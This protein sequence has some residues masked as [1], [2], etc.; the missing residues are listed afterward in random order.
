MSTT[1]QMT[2]RVQ[3]VS[4]INTATI[5]N[6]V[7]SSYDR[8]YE[9][10]SNDTFTRTISQGMEEID[11]YISEPATEQILNYII[12]NFG[13]KTTKVLTNHFK[14]VYEVMIADLNT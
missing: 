13:Y 7:F 3:A 10:L 14:N 8:K 4:T 1:N 12:D 6:D 9:I 11:V 2:T 5:L